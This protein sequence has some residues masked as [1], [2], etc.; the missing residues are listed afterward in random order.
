MFSPLPIRV[1]TKV[2]YP[3]YYKHWNG[4]AQNNIIAIWADKKWVSFWRK[5]SL[6]FL[7]QIRICTYWN[8]K[9]HDKIQGRKSGGTVDWPFIHNV[10]LILCNSYVCKNFYNENCIFWYLA[11][12]NEPK[13]PKLVGSMEFHWSVYSSSTSFFLDWIHLSFYSMPNPIFLF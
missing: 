4:V 7:S 1:H 12:S 6:N 2:I 11:A 13:W 9:K 10:P 5:T 3:K 8:K